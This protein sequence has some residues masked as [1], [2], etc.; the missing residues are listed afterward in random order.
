MSRNDSLMVRYD[1]VPVW[2]WHS[3]DV[4][5]SVVMV[6]LMVSNMAVERAGTDIMAAGLA[7][8]IAMG[9]GTLWQWNDRIRLYR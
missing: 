9:T 2:K 5:H 1:M 7:I 6:R 8:R 4:V 3:N